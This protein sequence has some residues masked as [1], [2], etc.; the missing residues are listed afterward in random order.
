MHFPARH[1]IEYFR[2]LTAEKQV[3]RFHR[4]VPKREWVKARARNEV[5]DCT[6]YAYAALLIRNVNLTALHAQ[7][8]DT[9]PPPKRDEAE[10]AR[11][12]PSG[13]GWIQPK[14][15]WIRR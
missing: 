14:R 4:G 11:R 7:M 3:T 8:S 6:V 9:S 13:G 10:E 5:L 2:Q 1:E 15:N 12:T